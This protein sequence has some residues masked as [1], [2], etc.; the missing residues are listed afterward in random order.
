MSILAPSFV[1]INPSYTVPGLLVDQTQRS[2]A[3]H[4]LPNSSIQATLGLADKAVYMHRMGIKTRNSISQDSQNELATVDINLSQVQ[5]LTYLIQNQAIFNRHEVA[6]GAAYNV[7]VPS[8]FSLALKQA[9]F[10][11]LRDLLLYG[12]QPEYGEGMLN[13]VGAKATVIPPDSNNTKDVL[14]M[15]PGEVSEFLL[16]EI[17]DIQNRTQHA[18]MKC[19]FTLLGPQRVLNL[20]ETSKIVQLTSYQVKGGGT[21]TVYGQIQSILE[22]KGDAILWQYD[23]TLKGKGANG[24]DALILTMREINLSGYD[25]MPNTNIF[26]QSISP[27]DPS[28]NL[29]FAD[30][31]APTEFITPMPG[32]ATHIQMEMRATPGWAVRP[33]ATTIISAAVEV[34]DDTSSGTETDTKTFSFASSTAT[35][36]KNDAG[37]DTT[38]SSGSVNTSAKSA[39]STATDSKNK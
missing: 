18:G 36:S 25:G 7:A 1:K 22:D 23:D 20:L 19:V 16:K 37:S 8:A 35:D 12:F 28:C 26:G 10:N 31:P 24:A 33:E 5:T 39:S 4:L 14:N 30:V 17:Q 6:A 3:F 2:G 11:Q 21:A 15:I 34:V 13:A 29:M 27:Q 38:A 32:T 9:H